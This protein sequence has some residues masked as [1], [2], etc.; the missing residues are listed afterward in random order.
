VHGF[1]EFK[2]AVADPFH[3]EREDLLTWYG[4]P[5]DPANIHED[6]IRKEMARI[7]NYRMA[8][9]RKARRPGGAPS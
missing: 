2:E 1:A 9:R 8:R 6:R 7:R 4:G 5:F 3:E